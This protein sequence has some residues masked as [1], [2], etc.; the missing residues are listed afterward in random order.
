MNIQQDT[1]EKVVGDVA[2]LLDQKH[3]HVKTVTGSGEPRHRC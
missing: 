1:F 3:A 2:Q